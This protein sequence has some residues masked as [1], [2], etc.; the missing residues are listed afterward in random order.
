MVPIRDDLEAPLIDEFSMESREDVE[1]DL[2]EDEGELMARREMEAHSTLRSAVVAT[3]LAFSLLISV[4]IFSFALAGERN[5]FDLAYTET[6]SLLSS[7]L[8][9][10][11][12]HQV[13]S[14]QGLALDL[15]SYATN[16]NGQW[17][18]VTMEDFRDH[19]EITQFFFDFKCLFVTPIVNDAEKWDE[20]TKNKLGR[21]KNKNAFGDV[22]RKTPARVQ[23]ET[24]NVE[25]FNING[26][27]SSG[28]GP[29]AP[30]WQSSNSSRT[31]RWVNLDVLSV[32]IIRDGILAAISSSEVSLS[33]IINVEDASTLKNPAYRR[34]VQDISE[35]PVSNTSSPVSILHVPVTNDQDETVAVVSVFFEIRSLFQN[36]LPLGRDVVDCVVQSMVGQIVSYKVDGQRVDF[37]GHGDLHAPQHRNLNKTRSLSLDTEENV[38]PTYTVTIYPSTEM[39]GQFINGSP[40]LL[41][42]FAVL[43]FFVTGVVFYFYDSIVKQRQKFI[44][45]Q[46]IRSNAILSSLFPENVRGRLFGREEGSTGGGTRSGASVNS[47]PLR[48]DTNS[49][50][51]DPT[52]MRLKSFL[53]DVEQNTSSSKP[54][55]DLFPNCTVLFADI[56][57]FTAVS[58]I[59]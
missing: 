5:S 25:M 45:D 47:N 24:S 55:A 54:I 23:K 51:V 44:L 18:E 6:V 33:R 27:R 42:G 11:F 30:L 14:V 21:W 49:F 59:C 46:A 22:E 56:S 4:G 2:S 53:S 9:D 48:I 17:P 12:H 8:V 58:I 28:R 16:T 10:R 37:I 20:Y 35:Q 13:K 15:Q 52:K 34:F 43:I 3:M 40:I 32:P 31:D 39:Y 1:D 7:T 29:F 57:G 38:S 50:T 26:S 36:L 19:V 41:S